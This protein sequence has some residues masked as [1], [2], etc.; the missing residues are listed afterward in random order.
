M[1]VFSN[2]S[3]AWSYSSVDSTCSSVAVL[4]FD[5]A[6]AIRSHRVAHV[7]ATFVPARK[8]AERGVL[9]VAAES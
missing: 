4:P 2:E 3:L 5:I 7:L 8:L 6:I 1:L 9:T